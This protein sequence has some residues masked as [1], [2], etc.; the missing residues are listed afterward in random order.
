ML[1]RARPLAAERVGLARGRRSGARRAARRAPSICR[2][3]RARRWTDTRCEPPTRPGRPADRRACRRRAARRPAARA[4]VRR[5]RSRP[6]PS[7]RTG[8]DAVVPIERVVRT[9]QR[10]WRSRQQSCSVPTSGRRA[11]T[12]ARATR[13]CAPGDVLGA[14][15][16]G[17]LAA[18]GVAERRVRAPAP[19][20][21]ARRPAPSCGRRA[22][23]SARPDL[24]VE[25]VMLAAAL[26]RRRRR[27]APAPGRGR[28][29]G[30]PARRSSGRSRPTSLVTSG[31]VSVGPHDLVRRVE[32]RARG[33]GGLLGRR[34]A[35]R[36]SRSSFGVRGATLVFGLPGNPVS[37]LVAALL[38]VRPALLALQGARCSRAAVSRRRRSRPSAADAPRGTSF[39]RARSAWT[40][41]GV[42]LD[43]DR[44]AGVAHDHAC[45]RRPTRSSTFRAAR[46]ISRPVQ[47]CAT[48]RL[49]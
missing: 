44:R 43:S 35:S 46:A 5:S 24:R 4:R 25:R 9:R 2:R 49:D 7:S 37:S 34:D 1:A 33:R 41:T 22:R 18:A 47:A 45:R 38:F 3:S 32:A 27:R 48:S 14:A 30:A 29:R 21:D 6:A 13:S 15:H 12:S 26:E 36:A 40:A 39:V 23:R 11:V 10:R 17:A 42:V 20:A 28:C 8:A 19:R 31:G 16:L